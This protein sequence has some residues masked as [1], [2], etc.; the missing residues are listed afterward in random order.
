M[1]AS[2]ELDRMIRLSIQK[3]EN[4][5][6]IEKEHFKTM[7]KMINREFLL[8]L[9]VLENGI[10]THSRLITFDRLRWIINNDHRFTCIV[11]NAWSCQ[12]EKWRKKLHGNYYI[13]FITRK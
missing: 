4:L 7:R 12:K 9:V 3:L 5:S 10:I 8:R 11:M 1:R 13:D 2:D 6:E